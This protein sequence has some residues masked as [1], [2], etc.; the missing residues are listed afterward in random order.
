MLEVVV[1]NVPQAAAVLEMRKAG[2]IRS[3]GLPYQVCVEQNVLV[4]CYMVLTFSI[5]T[6]E[7]SRKGYTKDLNKISSRS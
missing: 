6:H 7:N 5:S 4:Y 3:R 2:C 1:R